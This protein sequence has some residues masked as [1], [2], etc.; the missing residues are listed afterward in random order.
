M[1]SETMAKGNL[2]SV[3][4]PHWERCENE[5][6]LPDNPW[7]LRNDL[8]GLQKVQFALE[9][10]EALSVLHNYPS[11]RIVHN[12]MQLGQFL[13]ADDGSPLKLTDFNMAT[14]LE[15]EDHP[16]GQPCK[17]TFS[18]TPGNVCMLSHLRNKRKSHLLTCVNLILF[19]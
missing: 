18:E 5:Y 1:L 13:R 9:M 8:T 7:P 16:N 3:A 11:G 4:A 19:S 2:Y 15:W 17:F 12:D 14:I 10:A 6:T